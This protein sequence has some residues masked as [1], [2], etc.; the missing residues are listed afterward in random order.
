MTTQSSQCENFQ[1]NVMRLL[2]T[3]E[4]I[5]LGDMMLSTKL[6]ENG[7]YVRSKPL[8]RRIQI[9][10]VPVSSRLDAQTCCLVPVT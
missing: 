3:Q 5:L 8:L 10:H 4:K 9:V 2:L 7:I 6:V 1:A